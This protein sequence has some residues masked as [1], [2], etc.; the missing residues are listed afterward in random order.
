MLAMLAFLSLAVVQP[1]DTCLRYGRPLQLEGKLFYEF[2][3]GLPGFGKNP[4][5]DAKDYVPMIRLPRPV[6]V[7]R[8]DLGVDTERNV[9][10]MQLVFLSGPVPPRRQAGQRLVVTGTLFHSSTTHHYRQVLWAVKEFR[11]ALPAAPSSNPSR[12]DSRQARV[13]HG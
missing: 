7:C 2:H 8:G 9:R 10:E 3:Y 4:Q 6:T 1:P 5:T 12:A 11:S 13:R